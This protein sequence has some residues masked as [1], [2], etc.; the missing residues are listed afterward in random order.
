MSKVNG[1][2]FLQL[3]AFYACETVLTYFLLRLVELLNI[4]CTLQQF[5]L[6]M[7]TPW[8]CSMFFHIFQ[9]F[10]HDKS[11]SSIAI[12][13]LSLRSLP[14]LMVRLRRLYAG[15]CQ[16]RGEV[17]CRVGRR[18]QVV[19][20]VEGSMKRWCFQWHTDG[21]FSEDYCICLVFVLGWCDWSPR[22]GLDGLKYLGFQQC[23]WS[24]KSRGHLARRSTWSRKRRARRIRASPGSFWVWR[25]HMGMEGGL[26]GA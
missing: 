24:P 7:E 16:S 1:F 15:I 8:F 9:L 2:W 4:W 14:R 5:N 22:S 25:C 26:T 21:D 17:P 13:K 19:D 11:G 23:D 6:A 20:S 18:E 3:D 10:F 12:W